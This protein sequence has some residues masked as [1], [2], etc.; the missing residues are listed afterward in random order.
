MKTLITALT[1]TLLTGYGATTLAASSVDLTVKGLITPSACTPT[2]SGGGVV[3]HGKVSARDLNK[4]IPTQLPVAVMQL[5]IN[6]EAATVF[7][8]KG[9]D[10]R[11]GS[12]W[13]DQHW[14]LGLI[15]GGEKQGNI[16]LRFLGASADGGDLTPI[17]SEDG[18]SSWQTFPGSFYLWHPDS[19]IA[20]SNDVTGAPAPLAVKD[21]TSDV[22]IDTAI[23]PANTLTLI[24]EQPIDGSVTIEVRYL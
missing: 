4:E 17:R 23:A 13:L 9:V 2:L 21:L 6:C 8:L 16:S 20:F 24:E 11:P 18:G 3:D 12:G 10:N 19:L 14:G 15:N 1:A 22:Q 5:Q 7:A